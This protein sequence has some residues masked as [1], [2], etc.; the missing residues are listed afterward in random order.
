[1]TDAWRAA[2][3]Q[4]ELVAIETLL[5]AGADIDALD[6]HGQ[7]ALMNAA[8]DG[9]VAVVHLLIKRGANL[10]HR[11]KYGLTA[12]MLAV[13]R[14]HED[15]VRLLVDAG[16]DLSPRGSGSP[17]FHDRTALDLARA[18]GNAAI[19]ALLASPARADGR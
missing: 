5:A 12:V 11:A 8:R 3:E 13:I 18:R 9:R 14:D 19:A 16:A 17:G 7:T 10:D 2:T 6:E 15:I 1:M 4:G